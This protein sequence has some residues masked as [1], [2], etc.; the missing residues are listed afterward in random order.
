MSRPPVFNLY[1]HGRI[2]PRPLPGE[3]PTPTGRGTQEYNP[4]SLELLRDSKETITVISVGSPKWEY[5][6]SGGFPG[7]RLR[8]CNLFPKVVYLKPPPVF[9]SQVTSTLRRKFL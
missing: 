3:G 1:S 5:W 2:D 6:I 7:W 9:V 4:L 8:W